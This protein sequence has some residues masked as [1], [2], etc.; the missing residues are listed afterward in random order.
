VNKETSQVSEWTTITYAQFH[1]DVELYARYWS[2][3]LSA[4]GVA[5][6]SV[7]GLWYVSYLVLVNDPPPLTPRLIKVWWRS[8][9]RRASC[10]R[11]E[12]GWLRPAAFQPASS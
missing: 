3:V 4:D 11:D 12:Q 9:H 7:I 8:I 10:L 1:Q 2:S 5:P 6:G